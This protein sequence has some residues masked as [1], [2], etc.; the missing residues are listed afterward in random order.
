MADPEFRAPSPQE[1][2]DLPVLWEGAPYWLTK[3]VVLAVLGALVVCGLAWAA[4][5]RPKLVPRGLQNAGEY[6]YVFVRD[7]IARPFL[8]KDTDHWMPL[9]FSLFVVSLVWN[10]LAV[11]PG[12]Q[13]PVNAHLMF[14]VALAGV[15]YVVKLYVA[16]T[17]HGIFRYLKTIS[18][19]PGMSKA[20]AI[21]L[22]APMELLYFFV[23][24][25]FTHAVRLFA[26]MFAGHM[27]LAF[28]SAAG[29]WFLFERLTVPGF[30]VGVVGVAVTAV[31]TAFEVFIQ[32]LQ[33]YLF[34]MLAAMYLGSS[35]D[36]EH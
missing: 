34:T 1:L 19:P 7:Q 35:L 6:V 29:F 23:T 33:A 32:F 5:A 28:F 24:A 36:P 30:A 15:V 9:L 18:L 25:P 14:P 4:F 3:P 13:F 8:G 20:L 11:V 16:Y 17:R 12:I 27:L 31:L 21:A 22:Y 2:F 10:L 26:N